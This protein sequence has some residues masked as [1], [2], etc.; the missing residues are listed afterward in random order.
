MAGLAY[1]GYDNAAL[2][3]HTQ[4]TSRNKFVIQTGLQILNSARLDFQDF[5]GERE[6]FVICQRVRQE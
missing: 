2:R 4:L 3:V 6:Q 5:G 1:A